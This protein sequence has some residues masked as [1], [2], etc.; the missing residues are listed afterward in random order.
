MCLKALFTPKH[1]MVCILCI[2]LTIHT[3]THTHALTMCC[4]HH[5]FLIFTRSFYFVS[6]RFMD[7]FFSSLNCSKQLLENLLAVVVTRREV[8]GE[9]E[10]EHSCLFPQR[11]CKFIV[12]SAFMFPYHKLSSAHICLVSFSF[13]RDVYH[14]IGWTETW[15]HI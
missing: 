2:T 12:F 6:T 5:I 7:S 11:V 15:I 13:E 1:V 9:A 14:A 4:R 3:H 10:E 8:S